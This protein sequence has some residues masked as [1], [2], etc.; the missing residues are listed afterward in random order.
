LYA[1]YHDSGFNVLA[2]P[3]NQFG[4]QEPGT[5]EEIKKFQEVNFGGVE[6]PVFFKIDVNGKNAHPLWVWLKDQ[7]S[8]ALG[9]KGIKWNFSKFLID[10][11]GVPIER[12]EPPTNP[13][14]IE[15]R[16]IACLEQ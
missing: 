16:I 14:K 2:F 5:M 10:K 9:L 11:N 4:K 3:C 7:L 12:Y 6:F 8:G 15:P 1:K 13:L